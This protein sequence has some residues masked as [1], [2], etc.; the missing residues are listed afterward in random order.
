MSDNDNI[1][2]VIAENSEAL[3][4]I[5]TDDSPYKMSIEIEST[6]YVEGNLKAK[7]TSYSKAIRNDAILGIAPELTC[8]NSCNISK[9]VLKFNIGY[10]YKQYNLNGWS[11]YPVQLIVKSRLSGVIWI[12]WRCKNKNEYFVFN[13]SDQSNMER[14]PEEYCFCDDTENIALSEMYAQP[15][16]ISN[17]CDSKLIKFIPNS[18]QT[19]LSSY[20]FNYEYQRQMTKLYSEITG[21]SDIGKYLVF[22]NRV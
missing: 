12:K 15:K 7:E 8:D 19:D 11:Y 3:R 20:A 14:L 17:I 16:F 21:I 2:E 1:V 9:V 5:N 18:P 4:E 10:D 13:G 22:V 6:G